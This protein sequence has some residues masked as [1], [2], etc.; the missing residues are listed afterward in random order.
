MSRLDVFTDTVIVSME[1]S[2]GKLYRFRPPELRLFL[3]AAMVD[4][5]LTTVVPRKEFSMIALNLSTSAAFFN[6][7]A[8]PDVKSARSR[9]D[10]WSRSPLQPPVEMEITTNIVIC[11]VEHVLLVVVARLKESKAVHAN[12][13]RTY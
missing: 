13:P 7:K 1:S 6:R 10:G 5:K 8:C 4:P 3:E 11:N 12:N 9:K 2:T